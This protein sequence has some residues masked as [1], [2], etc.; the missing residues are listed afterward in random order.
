MFQMLALSFETDSTRIASLLLA[1]DGSNRSFSEIGISEGHHSLSHHRDDE[2][3]IQKVAQIDRFYVAQLAEFLSLLEAKKDVDGK[4]ILHN[5][6]IVYGCGNSDGNR[7]THS[8]LPVV[9][10]GNAGG[11]FNPGQYLQ[12]SPTPMCNLYLNMLDQM[13][14][15][16]LDRFGDSTGRLSGI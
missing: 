10:A 12:A 1:H 8:N 9:V 6:M 7:H 16:T 13:G 3:L 11:A 5:S 14:V 4:S 15:P 2:D